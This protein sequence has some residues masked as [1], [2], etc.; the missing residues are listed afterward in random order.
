MA[1]TVVGDLF[2]GYVDEAEFTLYPVWGPW[3]NQRPMAGGHIVAAPGGCRVFVHVANS[4]W[5]IYGLVVWT[6]L[7]WFGAAVTLVGLG[8]AGVSGRSV[9]NAGLLWVFAFFGVVIPAGLLLLFGY[10]AGSGRS[11]EG[12]REAT[13][14]LDFL[15]GVFGVRPTLVEPGGS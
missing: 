2:M 5:S 3:A 6:T 11:N 15:E 12:S 4:R 1:R 14:A 9:S 7:F 10:H 13:F 8:V